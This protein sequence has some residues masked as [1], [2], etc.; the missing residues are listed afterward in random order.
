MSMFMTKYRTTWHLRLHCCVL[1]T[2][3]RPDLV[4][5]HAFSAARLKRAHSRLRCCVLWEFEP[6]SSC[7]YT[8]L[9]GSNVKESTLKTL[10]LRHA[11]SFESLSRPVPVDIRVF[12]AARLKRARWKRRFVFAHVRLGSWKATKNITAYLS[13]YKK[14]RFKYRCIYIYIYIYYG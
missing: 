13:S 14:Y 1:T 9:L 3:I 11:A 8:C 12:L 7:R 2:L 5:I 10:L 6:T 4:D